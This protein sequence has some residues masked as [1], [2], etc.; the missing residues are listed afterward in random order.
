MR[1]N[2][3]ENLTKK[4]SKLTEKPKMNTKLKQIWRDDA[5]IDKI[6]GWFTNVGRIL[7]EEKVLNCC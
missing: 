5:S 2:M 1:K 4:N 6:I 3:A 7:R